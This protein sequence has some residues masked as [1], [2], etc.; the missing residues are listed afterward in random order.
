MRELTTSRRRF[1]VAAITF[2]GL[3]LGT[4]GPS[5]LRLSKVWA[6][7]GNGTDRSTLD[8]MVRMARLLFPHDALSDKFYGDVLD[9]ALSSTSP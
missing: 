7:S 5:A 4:I 6:Q 2:S 8:A 9:S 1:L 3:A